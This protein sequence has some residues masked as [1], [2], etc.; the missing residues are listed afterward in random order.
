MRLPTVFAAT[1]ALILSLSGCTSHS[2]TDSGATSGEADK[3]VSLGDL[4][5]WCGPRASTTT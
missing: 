1:V 4:T 3:P 5:V 2:A